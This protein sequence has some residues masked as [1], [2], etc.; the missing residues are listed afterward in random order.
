MDSEQSST[1]IEQH[2]ANFLS[3]AVGL[4][5]RPPLRDIDALSERE[6]SHAPSLHSDPPVWAV[7]K[8]G[9]VDCARHASRRRIFS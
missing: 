1:G 6:H 4:T 2:L 7:W 5:F 8:T 3:A 9:M